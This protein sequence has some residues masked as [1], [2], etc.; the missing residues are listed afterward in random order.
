MLP[1]IAHFLPTAEAIERLLYPYAE[2]VLHDLN[3]QKIAAIFNSFS[4][5]YIGD[6][7]LLEEIAVDGSESVIGPYLKV[8]WDGR[9]LK[10]ISVVIRNSEQQP[11]GLMCINLDLAKF[12]ALQELIQ[13]FIQPEHLISQPEE[14][15]KHDWQERMNIYVHEHLKRQHKRLENLSR[16]EKQ[17]LVKLLNKKGAFNQKNAAA[18]VG[19]ML[20]ISRAT[21]YKYLSE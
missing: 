18:Y 8:N 11:V 20:G 16:L 17:E 12:E 15:F 3:T 13:Q 1:E 7:S 21:V 9:K 10:A 5:R 4:N 19:K 6:D 14:L 2:V